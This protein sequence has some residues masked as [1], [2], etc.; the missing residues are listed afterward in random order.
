MTLF[1]R[2]RR[3]ASAAP[4]ATPFAAG[5]AALERNRIDEALAHFARAHAVAASAN[6]RAAV[7]NKRGVAHVRRGDREAAVGAFVDAVLADASFVPAIV[8][9]GNLLL[10]DDAVDEAVIHYEAALLLDD[11]YAAG[12]L[13]LG[14]AYKRLG[15]RGEAVREFRRANRLEG[16]LRLFR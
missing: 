11:T 9:I 3:F 12:H 14:V 5:V 4:P 7:A 6:E 16:R 15:R 2:L 10:E 8:N 13:N 1:A